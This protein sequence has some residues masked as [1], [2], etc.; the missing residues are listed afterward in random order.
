MIVKCY[1]SQDY[2]HMTF[3]SI[4]TIIDN[5]QIH[6]Q[7]VTNIRILIIYI[8]VSCCLRVQV[9]PITK[10]NLQAKLPKT[11]ASLYSANRWK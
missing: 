2:F 5:M 1:N 8:D 3:E 10:M 9:W 4:L 7:Q 11:D 6:C